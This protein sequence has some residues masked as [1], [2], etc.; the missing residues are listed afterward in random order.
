[1]ADLRHQGSGTAKAS[2]RRLNDLDE[3]ARSAYER[4]STIRLVLILS[5]TLA[6]VGLAVG[7]AFGHPFYFLAGISVYGLFPI[8]AVAVAKHRSR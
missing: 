4:M 7:F 2:L 3:R 6:L 8:F 5:A 1:M